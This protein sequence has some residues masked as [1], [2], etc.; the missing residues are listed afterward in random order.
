MRLGSSL[1][2]TWLILLANFIMLS[3]RN[4]FLSQKDVVAS[5]K[6]VDK[7]KF[8]EQIFIHRFKKFLSEDENKW[9]V[10]MEKKIK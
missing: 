7:K 5:W 4:I 8:Q 9:C 1:G 6:G 2:E 3:V 10:L